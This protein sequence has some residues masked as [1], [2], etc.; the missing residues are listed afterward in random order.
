MN[1]L[2]QP[3]MEGFDPEA[4]NSLLDLSKKGI[5]STAILALGYRDVD[6]VWLEKLKKVRKPLSE[7]VTKMK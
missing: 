5:K 6:I 3:P 1:K 7:F 2:I 4:L